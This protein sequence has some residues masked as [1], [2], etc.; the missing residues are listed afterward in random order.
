MPNNLSIRGHTDATAY[1][2][3][4]N[5]S[6]W[7]LSADR[8]NATRRVLLE[9]Q[10]PIDKIENVIGKAAKDPFVADNPSDPKNRRISI[11]LLNEEFTP[12]PDDV[13][14]DGELEDESVR[15][16]AY[17]E[18]GSLF[19]P[20]DLPDPGYRPSQGDVVFP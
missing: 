2:S 11:V 7:E 19:S 4:K 13:L 14:E 1:A 3:R 6:N 10:Y 17:N 9:K 20:D 15:D 8:A 12:S 18:D 5:Y 16:G